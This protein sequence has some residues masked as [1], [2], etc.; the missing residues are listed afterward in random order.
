MTD[1][2]DSRP[3]YLG[4]DR[5]DD[6]AR[7]LTEVASELWILKD[8]N[9]VLETLLA[10]AGVLTPAS[11]DAYNPDAETAARIAAERSAFTNRI[12]SAVLPNDQRLEREMGTVAR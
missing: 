6:I 5:L 3:A 11:I 12:L 4:S 2:V 1:G 8:R 10:E 7:M 9:M